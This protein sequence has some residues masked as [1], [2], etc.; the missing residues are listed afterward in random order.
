M[1]KKKILVF[2][3]FVIFLL[4]PV[5]AE[6]QFLFPIEDNDN[7][8]ESI[9]TNATILKNGYMIVEQT[10]RFDDR[11]TNG[12]EHYIP[13]NKQGLKDIELTDV[14]VY[15]NGELMEKV[16]SWNVDSSF[17]EK[18]GKYGINKTSDT[19]EI[20]MGV[21]E[22]TKNEFKVTYT[23]GNVIE[24]SK[25]GKY[26]LH[27]KFVNDKL[28][29]I[30]GKVQTKIMTEKGEIDRVFAFGFNGVAVYTK[31][32]GLNNITGEKNQDAV[33]L[34]NYDVS[35]FM[36]F[37]SQI[38]LLEISGVEFNNYRNISMTSMEKYEKAFEGSNYKIENLNSNSER[39]YDKDVIGK[40]I[41]EIEGFNSSS[42]NKYKPAENKSI[43]NFLYKYTTLILVIIQFLIV[44]IATIWAIVNAITKSIKKLRYKSTITRTE[45]KET[46]FRE[47][48]QDVSS[49]IFPALA[50]EKLIGRDFGDSAYILQYYFTKWI[51]EKILY[52]RDVE[53]KRLFFSKQII[54]IRLNSEFDLNTLED[55][56]EKKFFKYFYEEFFTKE[57]MTSKDFRKINWSKIESYYEKS[58]E[59]KNIN[60]LNKYMEKISN[61]KYTLTEEGKKITLEHFGLKNFLEDF[62]LM[63]ERKIQDVVLWDYHLELAAL[64]GIADKVNK[65]LKLHPEVYKDVYMDSNRINNLIILDNLN[66]S[67]VSERDSYVESQ[68]SS[69]SGGSSSSGGG[70]GFS[71]G[72]S[73]GGTR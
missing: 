28:S 26:F 63:D 49:D 9:V 61:K 12:T 24:K 56:L 42:S 32:T 43:K 73:G 54:Y 55:K 60:K 34:E 64:Y 39:I 37:N 52:I 66:R 36:D 33:I 31:D 16:H 59:Q 48:P 13:F 38:A 23:L 3:L 68:R 41:N 40:S 44:G 2:I 67:L 47:K 7:T 45:K 65:Q 1:V 27:W 14:K 4:I 30:A 50:N 10:W 62:T 25:D 5:S 70:S 29:D 57:E 71:G 17:E 6:N 46:Y 72:G 11:E 19:I 53:E 8:I 18:S 58:L 20:C 21:T 22:K 69:G 15:R 51:N 35:A